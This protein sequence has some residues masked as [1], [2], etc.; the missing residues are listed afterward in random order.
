MPKPVVHQ[1]TQVLLCRTLLTLYS[2][3][4]LLLLECSTLH[5]SLLNLRRSLTVQLSSQSRSRWMAAQTFGA[6]ATPPSFESSAHLLRVHSIL[7]SRSLMKML[8]KTRPRLP[9]E[10]C[11]RPST[12]AM[13]HWSLLSLCSTSQPILNPLHCPLVHRIL[14]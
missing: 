5:L 14:P 6:S 12:R 13:H 8:N 11:H 9:G 4:R 2:S 7:S 1:N 3:M 10:G